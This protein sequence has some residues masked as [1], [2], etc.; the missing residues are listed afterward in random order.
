MDSD[1][2]NGTGREMTARPRHSVAHA[3]SRVL[4]LISGAVVGV[5]LACGLLLFVMVVAWGLGDTAPLHQGG[6][7]SATSAGLIRGAAGLSLLLLI[8]LPLATGLGAGSIG[9]DPVAAR[10]YRRVVSALGIIIGVLV[11]VDLLAIITAG[12]LGR[13]L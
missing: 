8:L 4:L 5:L 1:T 3:A 2:T 6:W 7:Q 11:V 13:L 10:R 9:S 12:R